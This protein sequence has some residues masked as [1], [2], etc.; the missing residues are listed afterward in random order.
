MG[1]PTELRKGCCCSVTSVT[2]WRV[3]LRRTPGTSVQSCGRE[4]EQEKTDGKSESVSKFEIIINDINIE[5][6]SLDVILDECL[7]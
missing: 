2:S 1:A 4:G 7:I 6:L 3:L 5:S